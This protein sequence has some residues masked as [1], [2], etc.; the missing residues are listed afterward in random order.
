MELVHIRNDRT[1]TINRLLRVILARPMCGFPSPAADHEEASLDLHDLLV[2][3]PA[4]TVM[5]RVSGGSM[6]ARQGFARPGWCLCA[7]TGVGGNGRP[8]V[9][10]A[11]I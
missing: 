9:R 3:R 2:K 7:D 4:A 8:F 5:Y 11:G 1:N 6:S 10:T